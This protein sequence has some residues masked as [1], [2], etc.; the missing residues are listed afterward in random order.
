M[1]RKISKA[2]LAFISVSGNQSPPAGDGNF[3]PSPDVTERL[4]APEAK[5]DA[6]RLTA[7]F[8][9]TTDISALRYP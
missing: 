1:Q 4:V 8:V 2:P 9:R 5:D 7:L 6:K 3:T